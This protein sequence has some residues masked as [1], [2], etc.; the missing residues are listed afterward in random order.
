[1]QDHHEVIVH[2]CDSQAV[3]RNLLS[4]GVPWFMPNHAP[5]CRCARHFDP[6]AGSIQAYDAD[7]TVPA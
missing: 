4:L 7:H 2:G 6:A 1:M 3:L 5:G